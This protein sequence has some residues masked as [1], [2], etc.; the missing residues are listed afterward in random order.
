MASAMTASYSS[1]IAE[2]GGTIQAYFP[3]E[4]NCG[5]DNFVS[6]EPTPD[7]V[8][9]RQRLWESMKAALS[10]RDSI[11]VAAPRSAIGAIDN[12]EAVDLSVVAM[13]TA[14]IVAWVMLVEIVR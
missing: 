10:P 4:G 6:M 7:P 12:A 3:V 9:L 13:V 5:H 1:T 11:S 8:R 2:A 14:I